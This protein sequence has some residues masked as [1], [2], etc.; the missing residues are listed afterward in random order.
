ML[1]AKHAEEGGEGP[2][3]G[4]EGPAEGGAPAAEGEKDAPGEKQKGDSGLWTPPGS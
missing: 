4:G 3:E 1:Y 2:A